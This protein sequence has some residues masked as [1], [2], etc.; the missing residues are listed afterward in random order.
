MERRK[1]C[2]DV[3]FGRI[4]ILQVCVS[5]AEIISPVQQGFVQHFRLQKSKS[6]YIKKKALRE[7]HLDLT[8]DYNIEKKNEKPVGF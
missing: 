1:K 3:N 6:F 5:G 7:T 8:E 2:G 4:V